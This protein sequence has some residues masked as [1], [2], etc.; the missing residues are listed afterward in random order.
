V[1]EGPPFSAP[2]PYRVGEIVLRDDRFMFC[3]IE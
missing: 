2:I 1:S 3:D